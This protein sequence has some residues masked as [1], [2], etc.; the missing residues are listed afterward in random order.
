[1]LMLMPSASINMG[2]VTN[3][4][5][6]NR[7]TG[8]ASVTPLSAYSTDPFQL[9]SVAGECS[10]PTIEHQRSSGKLGPFRVQNHVI[11]GK[12]VHFGHHQKSYWVSLLR[13]FIRHNHVG[14]VPSRQA[15]RPWG[16]GTAPRTACPSG[17]RRRARPAPGH[18][19]GRAGR[20][21][22]FGVD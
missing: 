18:G 12:S 21:T 11:T 2:G 10:P 20:A 9:C 7:V 22:C 17:P 3:S 13:H 6:A 15:P 1:M 8:F 16:D 5:Y 4:R 19:L 14:T